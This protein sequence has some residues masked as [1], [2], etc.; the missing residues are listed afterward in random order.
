MQWYDSTFLWSDRTLVCEV[1][2][3]KRMAYSTFV[4]SALFLAYLIW[5]FSDSLKLVISSWKKC[6]HSVSYLY[7]QAWRRGEEVMEKG[8]EAYRAFQIFLLEQAQNVFTCHF[9][10]ACFASGLYRF[11]HPRLI[12]LNPPWWEGTFTWKRWEY[13]KN[14]CFS[15]GLCPLCDAL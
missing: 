1:L 8:M 7:K 9:G 10:N 5:L 2:G 3:G 14:L 12:N 6:N 4:F 13:R 15:F 11:P